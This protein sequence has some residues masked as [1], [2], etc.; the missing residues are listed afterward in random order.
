MQA[1]ALE[2][3]PSMDDLIAKAGQ[4][5]TVPQVAQQILHLTRDLDFDVSE[6]VDCL[7]CDP[8]L[9]LKILRAVNSSQYGF[10]RQIGNLRQAAALLGRRTLRLITLTFSLVD[11]LTHSAGGRLYYDYWRRALTMAVAAARFSEFDPAIDGDAAYSAGL[12][13]DI[14]IL[15]FARA[16]GENYTARY[17][18][19]PHG[20]ELVDAEQQAFGFNHAALGAGLLDGW[21]LPA[22][23]A[24]AVAGHHEVHSHS[25]P[26]QGAV[27]AGNLMAHVLWA[28]TEPQLADA[29]S[30]LR[31]RFSLGQEEF[32]RLALACKEDVLLSAELF[33]IRL[34]GSDLDCKALLDQGR[35]QHRVAALETAPESASG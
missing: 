19:V 26:V 27:H 13:A 29:R 16:A 11:S 10:A 7:K 15:V 8:A 33:D 14:G 6:V 18:Q 21:Q 32:G 1:K 28:R 25:G 17:L 35:R 22:A 5:H 24:E 3:P 20:P 4:L 9:A 34:T 12:L 30:R 23:V 31:E 2:M